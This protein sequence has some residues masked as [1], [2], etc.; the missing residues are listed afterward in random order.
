[1]KELSRAEQDSKGGRGLGG[2]EKKVGAAA[3]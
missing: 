2:G 3:D 1:M